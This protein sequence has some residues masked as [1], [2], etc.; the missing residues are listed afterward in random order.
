[1]GLYPI[2]KQEL[3]PLLGTSQF[4]FAENAIFFKCYP[5]EIITRCGE[6]PLPELG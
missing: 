4:S 1:M 3:M 6:V 5:N 2:S